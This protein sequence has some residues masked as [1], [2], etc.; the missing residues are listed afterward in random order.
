[1]EMMLSTFHRMAFLL[2]CFGIGELSC[3]ILT[4]DLNAVSIPPILLL[5][6]AGTLGLHPRE[7]GV[8]LLSKHSFH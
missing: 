7:W 8:T 1:M 2:M 3:L 4:L 6:M 5:T